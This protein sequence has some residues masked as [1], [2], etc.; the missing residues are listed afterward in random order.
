MDRFHRGLE[1]NAP[2]YLSCCCFRTCFFSLL[3]KKKKNLALV[4][5]LIYSI[6]VLPIKIKKKIVP[7]NYNC[8]RITSKRGFELSG[9]LSMTLD[10]DW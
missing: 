3:L 9:L 5:L 4:Y 2:I 7:I 1:P 6:I 10:N 8:S